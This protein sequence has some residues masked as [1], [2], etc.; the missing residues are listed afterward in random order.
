MASFFTQEGLE[1]RLA[2][3]SYAGGANRATN[4]D[5]RDSAQA[6]ADNLRTS[7]LNSC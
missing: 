5:I 2:V 7:E 3:L 6:I 4:D 1:Q